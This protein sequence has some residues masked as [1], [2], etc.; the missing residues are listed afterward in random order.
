V[1]REWEW[2]FMQTRAVKWKWRQLGNEGIVLGESAEFAFLAQCMKDAERNGF[3][4]DEHVISCDK[5]TALW[6]EAPALT[7]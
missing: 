2:E 3:S 1:S 4:V 6:S 5:G 7:V